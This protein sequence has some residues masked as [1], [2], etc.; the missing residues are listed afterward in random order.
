MNVLVHQGALGDW[1]L[2]FPVLRGLARL[3][4][5]AAATSWGKARLAAAMIPGIEEVSIEQPGWSAL[6]AEGASDRVRGDTRA[7]L[8][9]AEQIV[10][11]VSSGR[12]PWAEN[13]R[14]LAMR[15]SCAFIN[16]TPPPN[17][18]G[19]VTAWHEHQ[20]REQGMELPV[21]STVPPRRNP[22]GPLVIHPGSGGA[23]KC[24]PAERFEAVIDAVRPRG[25]AV[26]VLL[27]E[28]EMERWPAPLLDRWRRTHGAVPLHDFETLRAAL[29]GAR[30]YL[31][32]D[33][34]PTHV[35]AQLGIPTLAL[36]GPT[37][38]ALWSPIG[39]AVTLVAPPA[40]TGMDWLGVPPVLDRLDRVLRVS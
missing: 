15:A 24:W 32:N 21:D 3:G 20:L 26:R 8:G 4:P 1:V 19:H 39:P 18:P 17:W 28:A 10:T 40:R 5:T 30:A 9:S 13:L 38:P 37:D 34:G 11:F 31:G 22:D 16:P 14:D 35:A 12:D 25:V 27:G 7:L 23:A 2:T 33:S 29:A 36:F 6:H